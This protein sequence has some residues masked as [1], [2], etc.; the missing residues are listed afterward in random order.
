MADMKQKILDVAQFHI[1]TK[2]YRG[3]SYHVLSKEL[4]IKTA[5]IHYHFPKKE[6]LATALIMRYTEGVESYLRETSALYPD[7]P[8]G[9]L[10]RFAALFESIVAE[11]QKICLF[12]MLSCEQAA[13]T[14]NQKEGILAGFKKMETWLS[15]LL[16]SGRE[17]GCFQFYGD[18][19]ERA[20][21]LIACF[22]GGMQMARLA[23]G[24][25]GL[26]RVLELVR[27]GAD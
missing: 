9:G 20:R 15:K 16:A 17:K 22:E 27:S 2:G 4:G 18:A 21:L 7:D 26:S 10:R 19:G 24:K 8:E 23:K 25:P 6:D 12:G 13:L 14:E 5:S 3:F 1:Q 11:K